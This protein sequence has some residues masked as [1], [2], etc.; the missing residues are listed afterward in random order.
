MFLFFTMLLLTVRSHVKFVCTHSSAEHPSQLNF[1]YFTYHD[2]PVVGDSVPGTTTIQAPSG[3]KHEFTFTTFAHLGELVSSLTVDELREAT[4]NAP[5]INDGSNESMESRFGDFEG[6]VCYE[7]NDGV[8]YVLSGSGQPDIRYA[9]NIDYANSPIETVYVATINEASSG[10]YYFWTDNTD[11]NLDSDCNGAKYVGACI[12]GE[13]SKSEITVNVVS[14]GAS[15]P[16][17]HFPSSAYFSAP[18]SLQTMSQPGTVVQPDCIAALPYQTGMVTCMADG[19]WHSTVMCSDQPGCANGPY[20][21]TVASVT[22]VE[23]ITTEYQSCDNFYVAQGSVCHVVCEDGQYAPGSYQVECVGN[24]QWQ[25]VNSGTCVPN[26]QSNPPNQPIITSVAYDYDR[27]MVT[28]SFDFTNGENDDLVHSWRVEASNSDLGPQNQLNSVINMG[29]LELSIPS[30]EVAYHEEEICYTVSVENDVGMAISDQH[31]YIVTTTPSPT[32]TPTESPTSAPTASPT[33]VPSMSPTTEEPTSVPS[34]SPT[35][36]E[37]T[38]IPSVSPTTEEP[39]SVPS[40]S[41]TTE[42]P[43]SIPSVSPTT[44]EPTSAPSV[45]PTTKEPTSAP[46]MSPSTDEPTSAPSVSPST[47]P[48]TVPSASP[49]TEEPTSVPSVS[50]TTETPTSLPSLSPSA[51]EIFLEKEAESVWDNQI[52]IIVFAATSAAICC[53]CICVCV[54][55]RRK[56]D[57][58][59]DKDIIVEVKID[60][61]DCLKRSP[62]SPVELNDTYEKRVTE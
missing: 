26:S 53:C 8:G 58:E 14:A 35:T 40:V 7:G 18:S 52:L 62:L 55:M 6:F 11:V 20:D 9:Q 54:L 37:P 42:E 39:T 46:S 36:E 50:P 13:A 32:S 34:V 25:V 22:G 41:P 27:M 28:V 17:D 30:S 29:F 44:E 48:S 51:A 33:S 3:A 38:S 2:T 60:R 49:T 45:S 24:D 23:A 47:A 10:T 59:E 5:I 56:D 4:R 31:C 19:T 21:L 61:A 15:C 43:T 1:L 12:Q 57:E 16:S